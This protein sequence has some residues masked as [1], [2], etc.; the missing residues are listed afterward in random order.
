MWKS[1]DSEVVLYEL[2]SGEWGS[3]VLRWP[4]MRLE[5]TTGRYAILLKPS[6]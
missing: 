3:I 1:E 5:V 6:V 4:V 2:L